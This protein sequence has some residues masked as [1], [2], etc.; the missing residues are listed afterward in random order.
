MIL[1]DK[2]R[3]AGQ[4]LERYATEQVKVLLVR[5]DRRDEPYRFGD[6]SGVRQWIESVNDTLKGQ[7]DRNATAGVLRQGCTSRIARACS[8]WPP[9]SGTTGASTHRSGDPQSPTT[10]DQ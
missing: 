4:D 7:L 2:G 10:T 9:R 1:T 5:P 3:L 6:L 8:L